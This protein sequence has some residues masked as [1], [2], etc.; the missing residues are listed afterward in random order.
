MAFGRGFRK[1]NPFVVCPQGHI[2][3]S[4]KF[5]VSSVKQEGLAA[6][7]LVSGFTLPKITPCGITT[8]LG[9]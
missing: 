4:L 1:G 3:V 7:S 8:N 6:G 5:E 9:A 2:G